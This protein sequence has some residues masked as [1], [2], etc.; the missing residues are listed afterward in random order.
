MVGLSIAGLEDE[1]YTKG[2]ARCDLALEICQRNQD[3]PGIAQ[4][5]NIQG[6]LAR[7]NGDT[8]TA[9]QKY[10]AA[11]LAS[12]RTGEYYRETMNL[13]N[14]SMTAYDE[15]DYQEALNYSYQALQRWIKINTQ[16]TLAAELETIAGPYARLGFPAKAARLLAFGHL[17]LNEMGVVELPS[18]IGQIEKY[19]A[20]VKEVLGA[21]AFAKAWAEGNAMSLA[22]A[23]AYASDA[24]EQENV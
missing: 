24:V 9:R 17:Q 10:E 8:V 3:L 22:E 18:D 16:S 2:M 1:P 12:Q 11:L 19:T 6:E 21:E 7:L 13:T 4:A 20:Y 5:L 14:L 23:I 15:G